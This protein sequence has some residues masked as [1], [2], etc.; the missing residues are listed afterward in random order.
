MTI[1]KY[2]LKK[3]YDSPN[4]NARRSG[5]VTYKKYKAGQE[6]FGFVHSG[7]ADGDGIIIVDEKQPIV[8]SALE[9]I[10]DVSV[11]GVALKADAETSQTTINHSSLPSDFK[12]TLEDLK[13]QNVISS[14]V[15]KS[16]NSVNGMLIG[17]AI[18]FILGLYFKKS[19]FITTV[20]GITGGGLIGSKMNT[21]AKKTEPATS[22]PPK[23]EPTQTSTEE[24]KK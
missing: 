16:R 15:K 3:D 19:L 1:S 9:K 8:A 23:E 7:N 24:P 5:T 18:G 14:V 22:T 13:N 4:A 20:I 21:A 10:E 17:G 2:R 11:N 6:V 12:K